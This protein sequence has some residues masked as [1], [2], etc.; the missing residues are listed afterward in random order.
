[1]WKDG[2]SFKEDPLHF[3]AEPEWCILLL[4]HCYSVRCWSARWCFCFCRHFA[5]GRIWKFGFV[6][7]G[8]REPLHESSN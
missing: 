7:T 1:M 3:C 5:I 4:F 6:Y 8:V 2:E